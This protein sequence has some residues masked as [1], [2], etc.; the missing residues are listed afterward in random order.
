ME[1]E[2]Q[3]PRLSTTDG[4]GY[5]LV[6]DNPYRVTDD[7]HGADIVCRLTVDV[8]DHGGTDELRDILTGYVLL[9]GLGALI[10]IG[11][12][13]VMVGECSIE[14]AASGS[15]LRSFQFHGRSEDNMAPRKA[16][17]AAIEDGVRN[18]LAVFSEL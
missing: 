5:P 8:F 17:E 16:F 15:S 12:Q 4:L 2:L 18:V 14:E 11:P 3:I 6:F 1:R 13:A 7:V 10:G 9:G